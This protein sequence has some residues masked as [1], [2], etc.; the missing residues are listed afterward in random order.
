MYSQSKVGSAQVAANAPFLFHRVSKKS[1]QG[2]EIFVSGAFAR[3]RACIA[4][5]VE[6]MSGRAKSPAMG[7]AV[8]PPLGWVCARSQEMQSSSIG[9]SR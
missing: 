5:A 1:R 2:S 9:S 4:V 8:N 6:R 3:D 7:V